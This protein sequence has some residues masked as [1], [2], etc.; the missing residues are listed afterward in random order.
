MLWSALMLRFVCVGAGHPLTGLH[1]PYSL[2]N[3]SDQLSNYSYPLL[4]YSSTTLRCF[5][6]RSPSPSGLP[7]AAQRLEAR[8][9]DLPGT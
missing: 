3:I 6:C 7:A 5:F 4:Q 1:S 9:H 8:A 2:N